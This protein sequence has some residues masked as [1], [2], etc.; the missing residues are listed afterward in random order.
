MN[1]HIHI[2]VPSIKHLLMETINIRSKN[3]FICY[4][5]HKFRNYVSIIMLGIMDFISMVLL[6]MISGYLYRVC[7][8]FSTAKSHS[9][10]RFFVNLVLCK[11]NGKYHTVYDGFLYP[12]D[13][14]STITVDYIMGNFAEDN[15][16][17]SMEVI[18]IQGLYSLHCYLS[19][20][21]LSAKLNKWL[22]ADA[23]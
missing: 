8:Y 9:I 16:Y 2:R 7:R 21:W 23:F 20:P 11:N 19:K 3:E 10:T 1:C 17:L 5:L 18:D 6:L 12:N 14:P 13:L 4:N 15:R 22:F